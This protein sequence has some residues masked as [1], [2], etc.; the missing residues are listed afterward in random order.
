VCAEFGGRSQCSLGL[1]RQRARR[2]EVEAARRSGAAAPGGL[3]AAL[4]SGSDILDAKWLRQLG[5]ARWSS[6]LGIA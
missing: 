6:R 1:A 5:A 2:M 4:S 3:A